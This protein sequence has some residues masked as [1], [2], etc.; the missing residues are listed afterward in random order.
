MQK[1]FLGIIFS[2][3]LGGLNFSAASAVEARTADQPVST[4]EDVIDNGTSGEPLVVCADANEPDCDANNTTP[5]IVKPDGSLTPVDPA[6]DPDAATS[7]ADSESW[8]LIVSLA[9]LG[10]TV[11]FVIIINLFGRKTA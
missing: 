9:S 11:V 3:V 8:P 2:L 5:E 1:L 7:L 4:A 6:D 10:A